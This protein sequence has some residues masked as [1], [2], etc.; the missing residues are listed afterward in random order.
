MTRVWLSFGILLA[1]TALCIGSVFAVR[2]E[3]RRYEA[4]AA[5][6]TA[7]L[8]DGDTAAALAACD[9]MAGDWRRFRTVCGIFVKGSKLAPIREELEALPPM[10]EAG[11]PESAACAAR[12]RYRIGNV[13][14]ETAVF[15]CF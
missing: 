6:V 12:L 9:G 5:S 3:C 10:I 1:L 15:R 11:M 2:S 8:A 14:S 13:E 4:E 7:A